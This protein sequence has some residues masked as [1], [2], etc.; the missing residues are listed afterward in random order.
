MPII[1][2]RAVLRWLVPVT[3]GVAVIGGGAAVGTFAAGA[4]PALPP[5]TAAELLD[6][7]STSAWRLFRHGGAARRPRAAADR[8]AGRR[9]PPQR[10]GRPAHR[11]A[12][13]AGLV[14]RAGPAA[15]SPWSTRSVSRICCTTAGT[16]GRGAAG[17]TPP[18][19]RTLPATARRPLPSAPATPVDAAER[20][21]AAIDPTTAVTVGRSASGR[22]GRVRVGAQAARRRLAG[23]PGADRAGREGA[24][25]AAVRGARRR[26]RT[27]RRS[28][29]RSRR[30]TSAPRTPTSSGS[31]RRRGQGHRGVGRWRR[32]PA[33]KPPGQP[34]GSRPGPAYGR[35][36]LDHGGG[37]E[38]DAAAPAGGPK[39][40]RRPAPDAPDAD[41]WPRCSATCRRSAATGAA[42]GC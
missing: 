11:Q 42:G 9:R 14:R 39:A 19:H 6:D 28:R 3:A 17:P 12:H 33:G 7:L 24:R 23:A 8:R 38:L 2:N 4:E 34:T 5:R 13:P 1:K 18:S 36:R 31:T 37:R 15:D 30:S 41:C 21:L 22:A 32:G 35:H 27:G 40:A 25:A 20:A 29:W 26:G 10:A 16:S